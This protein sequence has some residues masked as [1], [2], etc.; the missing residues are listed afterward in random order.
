MSVAA[1][2]VTME[3]HP[4]HSL[5]RRARLFTLIFSS[6][7][8]LF[9]RCCLF[10]AICLYPIPSTHNNSTNSRPTSQHIIRFALEKKMLSNSTLCQTLN[11]LT[12][13]ES[14]Q[15]FCWL[16]DWSWRAGWWWRGRR[17]KLLKNLSWE[18]MTKS[19]RRWTSLRY[20][21][22][23]KKSGEKKSHRDKK[24]GKGFSMCRLP[25]RLP[26]PSTH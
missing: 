13:P 16:L 14:W 15:A 8:I 4:T 26:G 2:A 19:T 9:C 23:C 22:K 5:S 18:K 21:R 6:I 1:A 7:F 3:R 24:E 25:K 12:Y 17:K 11:I 10:S 20:D